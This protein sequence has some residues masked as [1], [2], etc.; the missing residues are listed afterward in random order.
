MTTPQ[1]YRNTQV[2]ETFHG[3]KAETVFLLK[4]E[5]NK[6]HILTVYTMRLHSKRIKTVA[7]YAL[8]QDGWRT[9]SMSDYSS[10]IEHCEIKRLTEPKLLQIH[11]EAI[12]HNLSTWMD[13][14]RVWLK[15]IKQIE[16]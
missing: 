1:I 14:V 9:R 13:E 2:Q 11:E 6:K 4:E 10:N 12:K 16:I 5:D 8:A 15:N 7:S 3:K